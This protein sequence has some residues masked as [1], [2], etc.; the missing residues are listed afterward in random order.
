[1][2]AITIFAA[3]LLAVA[4][5]CP[6]VQAQPKPAAKPAGSDVRYFNSLT[7]LLGDLSVDAF[8]KETRQGGKVTAATLDVCYSVTM[9]SER[10]DR[11]VV[12]LKADGQKLTGSGQTLEQKLPVKVDLVRKQSGKTTGFEGKIT[13]GSAVSDV[14]SS[15]NTDVSEAEFQE[16]V[17]ADDDIAAAPDDFTEVSPGSLA[18][19]IKRE[20]L[21]DFVKSL[22]DEKVK[23]A[24]YSLVQDCTVLRTGQQVVKLDVDVERAPALLAKL[25]ASPNVVAAGYT[26]GAYTMGR[27]ARFSAAAWRDGG[28]LN[29][30]KLGATIAEAIGKAL[31]AK[32][33]SS[34][35]DEATGELTLTYKRPSPSI[36]N[37]GLTEVVE[38]TVLVG[39]ERPGG[40][41]LIVWVGEPTSETVD[42]SGGPKLSLF[43]S[44][45]GGT[46]TD[47]DG[48][49]LD[50][51]ETVDALAKELKG[52]TWDAEGSVWK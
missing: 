16:S 14:A 10:K 44:A 33:A 11:F 24:Y 37:L 6:T 36:P 19:K 5:Y 1:M 3:G 39:P 12:D 46:G 17:A 29:H 40:D 31:G 43:G 42:E 23:V 52:Q 50:N 32:L 35:R 49:P 2:R 47:D 26:S 18:F 38:L 48:T 34:T 41:K 9:T 45:S 15:D 28:K 30:E 22:K 21:P 51:G 13:I 25:K 7:D 20:A 27:A 8:L 4:S